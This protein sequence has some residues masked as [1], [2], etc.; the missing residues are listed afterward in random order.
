VVIEPRDLELFKLLTAFRVAT[1]PMLLPLLREHF[2][3]KTF[4]RRLLALYDSKH[5]ARPPAQGALD[6]FGRG[7]PPDV[8]CLGNLGAKALRA[9]GLDLPATDLERKAAELSPFAL[10]HMLLTSEVVAI[11][12]TA[13]QTY[14]QVQLLRVLRDG[15][16]RVR[17]RY[18]DGR[19]EIVGSVQP[20][21]TLILHEA[22][23]DIALLLEIDRDTMPGQ[24][25]DV[26]QSSFLKKC[27]RYLA[28]WQDSGKIREMLHTD[29]FL[30]LTVTTSPQ[31]ATALRTVARRAD[32]HE[33]GTDI[34]WFTSRDALSPETVLASPIWTTAAGTTGSLF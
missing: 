3:G 22:G 30:V 23:R 16:L 11:F 5:L 12:L 24:R 2:P 25:T 18:F 26:L 4:S 33:C 7:R 29:D 27:R 10:S 28:W 32:P 19:T 17:V 13:L 20:D 34:F 9:T 15:E 14:P 8:Y 6:R 1:A 31:H 21:A